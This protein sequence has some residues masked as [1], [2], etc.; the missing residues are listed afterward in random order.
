[1]IGIKNERVTRTEQ[2]YSGKENLML[3]DLENCT[4]VMPFA[5]KCIYMKNLKSC[6]IYVGACSGATFVEKAIDCQIFIQSHQIRIHNSVNTQ[7]YLTAKS[8]P[9]IE[10]CTKMGFGPFLSQEQRAVFTYPGY[11]E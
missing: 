8:N 2:E 6:R 10:H 5:V 11:R 9:I 7:F 4:V 1:M 3:E